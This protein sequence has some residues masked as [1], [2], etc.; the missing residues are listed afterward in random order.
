MS[1]V[2]KFPVKKRDNKDNVEQIVEH[3]FSLQNWLEKQ[4]GK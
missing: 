4:A 3:L 1:N 2:I